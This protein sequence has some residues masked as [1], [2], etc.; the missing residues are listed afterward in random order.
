[1]RPKLKPYKDLQEAADAVEN[2]EKELMNKLSQAV[3]NPLK[4]TI[5]IGPY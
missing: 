1:M 5:S 3:T 2:L 4:F